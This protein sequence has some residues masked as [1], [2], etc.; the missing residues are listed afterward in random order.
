M[1][2]P[3]EG[4]GR[5]CTEKSEANLNRGRLNHSMRGRSLDE[6]SDHVYG[7]QPHPLLTPPRCPCRSRMP[8]TPGH[9]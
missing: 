3:G 9:T 6:A 2:C 4:W 7:G 1:Q 5:G 8:P